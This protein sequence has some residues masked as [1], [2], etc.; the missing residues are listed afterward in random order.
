MQETPGRF[1]LREDTLEKGIGYPLQY[2]WA[3]SVTQIVKNSHATRES[4][5]LSTAHTGRIIVLVAQWCLT[6]RNVLNCS[7][8]GSSVSGDSLGKNAGVCCHSVLQGIFHTQ[9]LNP[10]LLHCRLIL[11]YLS[12]QRSP[13]IGIHKK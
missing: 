12:H 11:Y 10:D 13:H 3:S 5:V 9:A 1:L 8:L 7:L 6:L 4:W 2:S